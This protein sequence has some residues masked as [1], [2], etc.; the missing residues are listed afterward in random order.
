MNFIKDIIDIVFYGLAKLSIQNL[1]ITFGVAGIL[2]VGCFLGCNYYSRL[3]NKRYRTTTTHKLLSG[4]ASILTFLFVCAFVA[5]T[6][7]E[8]AASMKI[9]IWKNNLKTDIVFTNSCF[10]KAYYEVKKLGLEDFT[11]YLP[12]EK[13]GTLIPTSHKETQFRAGEVYSELACNNFDDKHRF[14]ALALKSNF[15]VAPELITKDM[16]RHFS[17]N[18]V[19][20]S[21]SNGIEIAATIIKNELIAQTPKVIKLARIILVLLFLIVQAIPFGLIGLA[22]YKDL[23]IKS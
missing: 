18:E 8:D 6:F 5:F 15:G 11:N 1:L 16:T 2:S 23:K 7:W 4:V 14:L 9:E 20:Y 10:K 22:A 21:M 17:K 3:W 12:P 19:P 13:G